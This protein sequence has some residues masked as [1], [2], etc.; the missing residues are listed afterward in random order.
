MVT[1]M[2]KSKAH[3]TLGARI[4]RMRDAR[5]WSQQQLADKVGVSKA[6]ISHW[7]LDRHD[8]LKHEH[9]LGLARAFGV[10][11][12]NIAHGDEDVTQAVREIP[13]E[14]LPMIEQFLQLPP[15]LQRSVVDLIQSL[16]ASVKS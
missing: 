9:L 5:G 10:S 7:E 13:E 2:V 12:T 11:S 4:R 3:E 1:V 15:H 8:V 14:V 6:S 16:Y